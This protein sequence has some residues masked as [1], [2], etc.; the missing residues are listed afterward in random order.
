MRGG[1]EKYG[2]KQVRNPP[3]TKGHLYEKPGHLSYYAERMY[4]PMELEGIKYYL[5]PMNCPHHHMI[6]NRIVKSYRDLPLRL[7]EAGSLYRNELSGVTYGLIRVRGMTQNDSH[8]YVTSAQLKEEFLRVLKMFEEVYK[9]M[10][11]KD[12]HSRLSLPDFK[13]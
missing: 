6:F 2:Y 4:P 11:I 7:A 5:R 13:G 3:I 9:V 1:E 8:I 10:G 12:Y